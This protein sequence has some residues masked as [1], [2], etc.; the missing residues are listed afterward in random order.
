MNKAVINSDGRSLPSWSEMARKYSLKVL[1]FL[2]HDK[3]ELSVLFCGDKKMKELNYQYRKKNEATDILSF[4]LG[5]TVKEGGK[6][7]YY[8]GDII[9]SLD[10]LCKNAK[11]FKISEDE[12]LRR[13][14]IHGI[15]HLSGMEHKTLKKSEPMLILQEE[16]LEKLKDEH[17]IPKG[18]KN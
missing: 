16:I 3:W 14:L 2:N 6:K 1:D 8:P 9:I 5:E 17:I 15:L 10:T 7:I 4:N 11:K 13:L 18:E 12:E